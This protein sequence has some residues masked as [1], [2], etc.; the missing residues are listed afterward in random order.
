MERSEKKLYLHHEFL[1][2][3]L[4]EDSGKIIFS[5]AIEYPLASAIL[6]ELLMQQKIAFTETNGKKYIKVL[7]SEPVGDA[8]LDEA[9][10]LIATADREST[11]PG[12]VDKLANLNKLYIRTARQ[13]C[14]MGIL[15]TDKTQL[16]LLFTQYVFPEL[17]PE[18]EKKIIERMR[19]VIFSDSDEVD[20]R[21]ALLI[22]LSHQTNL[23][24]YKF[25]KKELKAKK[26]RIENINKGSYTAQANQEVNEIIMLALFVCCIMPT[27]FAFD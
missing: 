14:D 17:D 26:E 18:P 1:L 13:L 7:S 16:L 5:D 3:A 21:D 10:A 20:P 8:L 22:A 4:K 11:L 2:L 19:R 24:P 27:I 23:L 6:S 15:K 12:W 25:D 9:I